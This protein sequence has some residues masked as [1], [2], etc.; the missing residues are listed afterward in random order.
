[1]NDKETQLILNCQN[2]DLNSFGPLYDQYIKKIY[3]FI[4][5][6][7]HHKQTAEG[8]TSTTFIKALKGIGSFKSDGGSFQAWVYRI[9]RNTVIDYYRTKKADSSLED[10]WD[11]STNDDIERD[12][13]T[14]TKLEKVQQYLKKLPSEQR[15]II[16]LRLWSGLSY[17]EIAGIVG[18]TESNCKVI[19]SRTLKKLKEDKMF[20]AV[21]LF[22]LTIVS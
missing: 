10:V 12:I 2:G 5:F 20:E 8:L 19:L 7:T 11:L 14:A 9:A 4:Y 22:I 1:M 17:Q 3:D 6:K 15:D 21:L 18:K 13:N 16:L